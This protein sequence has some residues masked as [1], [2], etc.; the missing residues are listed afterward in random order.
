MV[1]YLDEI[2]SAGKRVS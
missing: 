1:Y 2:K